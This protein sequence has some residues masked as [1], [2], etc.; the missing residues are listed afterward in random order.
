MIQ[1]LLLYPPLVIARVGPSETPCDSFHWGPSD[2]RP[3]G[4]GKTTL[5]PAE[6]LRVSTG[7]RVTS[8]TPTEI[9]FKDS[10]GFRP[11]CPFLELHGEW[12][13][14]E[15]SMS[16]P[17]TAQVLGMFGLTAHDLR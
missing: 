2:L 14:E 4:T 13:V 8:S 15:V 17:I 11:V 12:I 9:I 1:K 16:G 7:G 5:Q 3:R 6:T 10:I